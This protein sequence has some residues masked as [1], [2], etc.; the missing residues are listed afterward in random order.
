MLN[1]IRRTTDGVLVYINGG[2]QDLTMHGDI[3]NFGTVWVN[4]AS[5]ANILSLAHV[6]SVC[7]ITM[8]SDVENALLL[9]QKDGSIMK[10][11]KMSSG[12]YY[13]DATHKRNSNSNKLHFFKHS[14]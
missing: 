7:R 10:F 12:L 5:M 13:Y 4:P 3:P 6:T 1:N 2:Y 9:H 11:S 8:D 14:Q